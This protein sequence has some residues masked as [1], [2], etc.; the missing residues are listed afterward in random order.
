MGARHILGGVYAI[1]AW[2]ARDQDQYTLSDE[3][4]QR[5]DDSISEFVKA[6]KPKS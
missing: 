4:L 5:L 6:I 2:V 3:L 1:D